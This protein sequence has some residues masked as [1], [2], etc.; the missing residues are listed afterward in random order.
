MFVYGV[1]A[2]NPL[3]GSNNTNYLVQIIIDGSSLSVTVTIKTD[4]T[5][6]ESS[7]K[8]FVTNLVASLSSY[9]P[10]SLCFD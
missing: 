7:A 4:S 2:G 6:A 8:K 10:H 5:M 3:I 9:S 1:E